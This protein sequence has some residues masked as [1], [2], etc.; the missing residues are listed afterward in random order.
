M[1]LFSLWVRQWSNGLHGLLA[2]NGQLDDTK[3]QELQSSG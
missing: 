2:R 3:E 1:L